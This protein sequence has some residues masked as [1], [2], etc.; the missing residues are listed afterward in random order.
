LGTGEDRTEEIL[1]QFEQKYFDKIRFINTFDD[2]LAHMIYAGCDALLV[3]SKYEPCGLTQLIAMRYGT[4]PIVRK[5]G[6]LAD[7]VTD[8]ETGFVFMDYTAEALAQKIEESY[9]FWNQ[10]SERW[11]TMV[12]LAMQSDFSWKNSAESY[13]NLTRR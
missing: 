10:Q 12:Q 7:T 5:T 3:P 2:K 1:K 8:N 13:V 6:G 4:L 11:A 9:D